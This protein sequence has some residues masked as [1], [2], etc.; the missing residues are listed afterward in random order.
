[1]SAIHFKNLYTP[2]QSGCQTQGG[3]LSRLEREDLP[4]S[5]RKNRGVGVGW[6]QGGGPNRQNTIADFRR[7]ISSGRPEK[8]CPILVQLA[9][10]KEMVKV[11]ADSGFW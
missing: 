1:M 5:H 10:Q 7:L 6:A 3:G 4:E 11:D 2:R 9:T 8:S